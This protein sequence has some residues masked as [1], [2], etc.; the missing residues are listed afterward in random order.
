MRL[1]SVNVG[2][3][4]PLKVGGR[5][6][7][8]GIFKTPLAGP[9]EVGPLGLAGDVQVDRKHHGGPDQAVYLYGAD[10]YAWW[11][12]ELGRELPAGTFGENLTLESVGSEPRLGDRYRVGGVLLEVT[13]PRVPCNTLAAR[14][15]EAAFVK[16][17]ARAGRWGV[18]ARVLEPGSLQAGQTMSI[19]PA[20]EGAATVRD[21]FEVY[22]GGTG[23]QR[24]RALLERCLASPALAQ[25]ARRDLS[26]LLA[27]LD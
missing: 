21:L 17:F 12:R 24:D 4:R 16:S 19:T 8:T 22:T 2:S 13:A 27:S 9:V 3:T 20:P 5:E 15:G 14:M 18:Y 26:E 1:L 6:R 23:M 10:D 7:Q 25:R 11:S